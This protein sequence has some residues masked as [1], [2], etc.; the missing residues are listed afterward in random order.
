M[1]RVRMMWL[2]TLYDGKFKCGEKVCG[3]N[4]MR[5]I[6]EKVHESMGMYVE[7]REIEVENV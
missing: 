2:V 7:V 4:E 3:V 1:K 5:R 6:V